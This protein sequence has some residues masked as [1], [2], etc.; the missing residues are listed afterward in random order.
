MSKTVA[1]AIG[2]FEHVR[3]E[4][5]PLGVLAERIG[6]HPS[7][8]LRMLAPMV[9]AGLLARGFDGSYRLGLRLVG[10]GQEVLESLDL[11]VIAHDHLVALTAE[12]GCTVHLAQLIDD[13]I[14]YVDKADPPSAVRMWSRIGRPVPLHTAAASKAILAWL[15]EGS[16]QRLL[17]GWQFS[18]YTEHTLRDAGELDTC[19]ERVRARGWATDAAEF[20]PLVHCVGLALRTPAGVPPAAVSV[21]AVREPPTAEETE[22]QVARL[23]TVATAIENDLGLAR[24][25][26]GDRGRPA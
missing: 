16:R 13:E 19:L 24:T 6:V 22:A 14:V 11:P 25:A 18:A 9:E 26:Q 21:S 15:D 7:A 23:R 20:E 3:N 2:A 8:A 10:L 1:K 17:E 5:L 12:T 4:P